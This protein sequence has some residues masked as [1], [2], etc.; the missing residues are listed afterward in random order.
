ML[1]PFLLKKHS[2][3]KNTKLRLFTVAHAEDNAIQLKKDL[4]RFLYQLRIEAEVFVIEMVEYVV[5]QRKRFFRQIAKS[6]RTSTR[7]L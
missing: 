2:T 4:E 6:R 5:L 7:G 1:L 3:W